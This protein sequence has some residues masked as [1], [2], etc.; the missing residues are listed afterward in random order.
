MSFGQDNSAGFRTFDLGSNK[1]LP[2]T[3]PWIIRSVSHSVWLGFTAIALM[4]LAPPDGHAACNKSMKE[5]A[6]GLPAMSDPLLRMQ[7][8]R[9]ALKTCGD[10]REIDLI[11]N[12]E[13]LSISQD[14]TDESALEGVWVGDIWL[15][16][17]VGLSIPLVDILTI[18]DGNVHQELGR[19]MSPDTVN[20]GTQAP[21]YFLSLAKARLNK[22]ATGRLEVVDFEPSKTV[23]PNNP[24]SAAQ[25]KQAD[26]MM[27]AFTDLM[28]IHLGKL[29][30]IKVAGDRLL[31]VDSKQRV[32]SYVRHKRSDVDTG[33]AFL[34]EAEISAA[35][36]WP[37]VLSTLKGTSG[38]AQTQTVMREAAAMTI[39]LAQLSEARRRHFKDRL[40]VEAGSA[41]DA[42]LKKKVLAV[43]EKQSALNGSKRFR[44]AAALFDGETPTAFCAAK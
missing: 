13:A 26:R 41:E 21:E 31:L 35:R 5:I 16:V 12:S 9:A 29:T 27:H 39:E 32:R 28:V 7:E 24:Y 33:H 14:A 11:V 40:K 6:A 42:A 2:M 44:A 3:T 1:G 23:S 17:A 34:L 37:C 22:A 8:L 19:W 4:A 30:R 25:G 43:L 15:P 20:D 10:T 18:R 36:H 38:D